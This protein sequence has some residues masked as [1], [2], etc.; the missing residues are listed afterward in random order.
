MVAQRSIKTSEEIAEI[1]KAC[2][3]TADMYLTA[4]A[5]VAR[6]DEGV[7]IVA[8]DS[9]C[10]AAGGRLSFP[11]AT[12]NGQTLHNCYYGNT[13]KEGDMFLLDAG[14]ETAMGYAGDMSRLFRG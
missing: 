14:A 4:M 12:I 7:E 8:V 1:E 2:N 5:C 13:V 3:I 6:R 9:R 10:P 11:V